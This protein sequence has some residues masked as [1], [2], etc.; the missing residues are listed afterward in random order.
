MD[1]TLQ[2]VKYLGNN[3]KWAPQNFHIQIP[4]T[5]MNSEI[6]SILAAIK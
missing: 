5:N 2:A 6:Y 3:F 4:K 1:I